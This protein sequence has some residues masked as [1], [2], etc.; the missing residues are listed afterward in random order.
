VLGDLQHS[1][2]RSEDLQLSSWTWPRG[3]VK[4][5]CQGCQSSRVLMSIVCWLC[6]SRRPEDHMATTMGFDRRLMSHR[7]APQDPGTSGG[8]MSGCASP[9]IEQTHACGVAYL[10]FVRVCSYYQSSK[11]GLFLRHELGPRSQR[12]QIAGKGCDKQ[13]LEYISD[14]T[15]PSILCQLEGSL[16]R[17]QEP[18]GGRLKHRAQVD[19]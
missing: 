7:D 15:T 5:N 17:S 14:R 11:Q 3:K 2:R 8:M 4:N 19:D 13:L 18:L 9:Q 6:Q 12:A 10:P 16:P 1:T